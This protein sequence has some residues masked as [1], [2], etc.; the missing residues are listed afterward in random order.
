MLRN[1]LLKVLTLA[2][3]CTA[4][5]TKQAPTLTFPAAVVAAQ[6]QQHYRTALWCIYTSHLN[7]EYLERRNSPDSDS[8]R[9]MFRQ[10]LTVPRHLKQLEKRG[11]STCFQF[12][13]DFTKPAQASLVERL[14]GYGH[15]RYFLGL[16]P[17]SAIWVNN[18]SGLIDSVKDY[19][20]IRRS[21]GPAMKQVQGKW[22]VIGPADSRNLPY[23]LNEPCK[24]AFLQQHQDQ[25]NPELRQLCRE[26]DIVSH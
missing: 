5:T 15:G 26:K 1:H 8:I 13:L 2:T 3:F 20:G 7:S 10:L 25:L 14:C 19:L 4:C 24:V 12:E 11:P 9:A 23:N 22:V 17:L 16:A 18:Q 21:A 6:Q